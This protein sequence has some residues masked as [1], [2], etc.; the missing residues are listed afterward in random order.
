VLGRLVLLQASA[1]LADLEAAGRHAEAA[2]RLAERHDLPLVGVFT[3]WYAALR[4][5]VLGRTD[6]ARTA[7][8]TAAAR[9]G[10]TG[11]PGVEDGIL[12]LALL[13]LEVGD[14]ARSKSSRET[15]DR[16]R[17]QEAGDAVDPGRCREAGEGVDRG[18]SREAA[19]GA[20]CWRDGGPAGVVELAGAEWGP[21]ESWARPLVLLAQGRRGEAFEAARAVPDSPPDLLLEART[22][23]HVIAVVATA[24]G[25]IDPA[26]RRL[27]ERLRERLLPAEGELAGAGSGLVTLGPVALYLGHLAAALGRQDEAAGYFRKA[28]SVAGA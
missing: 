11:M 1:A 23:L 25:P 19:V 21:Y 3:T 4:L 16:G 28:T 17:C 24:E 15:A 10:G 18:R 8:R 2:D 5:A 13:C 26:G 9:L 27:L 7:Y 14:L 22:C 6:E 20:W 12:P